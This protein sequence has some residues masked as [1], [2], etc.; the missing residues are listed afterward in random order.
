MS[1]RI[2]TIGMMSLAAMTG[3]AAASSFVTFGEPAPAATPSIVVMGTPDP[4]TV[5]ATVPDETVTPADPS[6]KALSQMTPGSWQELPV[7]A[8]IEPEVVSPSIVAYGMPWP[9]VTY[10]KVAAIP[11][12]TPSKAHFAPMV[13]RGGI[14]GDAFVPA[15]APQTQQSA[16]P[17]A[18]ASPADQ[19]A[20][21]DTPAAANLVPRPQAR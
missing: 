6:Q 21:P 1:L 10:E 14:V 3:S 19:P 8:A 18:P 9:P 4:M 7:T 20:T 12:T 11:K 16:S 15:S 17:S 13:I 5:A 2:I